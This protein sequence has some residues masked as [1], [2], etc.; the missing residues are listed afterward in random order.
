MKNFYKYFGITAIMLFSFYYTEKIALL[1]R[2][3]D[4]IYETISDVANENN[5]SYVNAT[6]YENTIIPGV[7]GL[8]V[9]V[10]KSFQKMK[11][12]GAFNKYYLVF[13]QVKPEISLED[14]K[15]KMITQ[16][17]PQKRSISLIIEDNKEVQ[18]YFAQKEIKASILIT[19]D[20][21]K[22]D[23]Y[24]EQINHD[25]KFFKDTNG[26]LDSINQNHNIC[27][28]NTFNA[29]ICQKNKNYLVKP[30]LELTTYNLANVKSKINSGSIILIKKSAKL[31]DV[32][33][34]LNQIN[35]KGL[36]PVFL[37]ELILEEKKPS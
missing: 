1:M 32:K 30:S 22:R 9:N 34:L 18:E 16:G 28:V 14:H 37:S 17:N 8:T 3:K 33:I 6:I 12:F 19:K 11:S 29:Q 25:S 35:Y 20:T 13:D 4:P 24:L 26:L 31:E 23:S 27:I 5:T 15:D 36:M 7:N 10:D 2:E 21:F